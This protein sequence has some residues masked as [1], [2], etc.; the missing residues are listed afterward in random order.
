[1][2]QHNY[3]VFTQRVLY[4]VS[5]LVSGALKNLQALTQPIGTRATEAQREKY[6]GALES[7]EEAQHSL[8]ELHLVVRGG[9]P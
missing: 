6:E 2:V 5:E 4:V 9:K 8:R 3:T 7:L 1:M